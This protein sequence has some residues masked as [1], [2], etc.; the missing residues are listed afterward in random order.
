[1]VRLHALATC[2]CGINTTAQTSRCSLRFLR[3]LDCWLWGTTNPNQV[4]VGVDKPPPLLIPELFKHLIG[5]IQDLMTLRLHTPLLME[6][7]THTRLFYCISLHHYN[8]LYWSSLLR[9]AQD[10]ISFCFF[11][12]FS[13]EQNLTNHTTLFFSF[14]SSLVRYWWYKGPHTSIQWSTC[15]AVC[16][17]KWQHLNQDPLCLF[18]TIYDFTN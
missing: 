2:H 1:M 10:K 5:S 11:C 14:L 6:K 13:R 4:V 9:T 17:T 16:P 3:N 8:Q 7:I 18:S 12:L 15:V